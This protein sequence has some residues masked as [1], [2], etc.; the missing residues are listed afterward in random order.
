MY[1][2]PNKNPAKM[3]G[4]LYGHNQAE[5]LEYGLDD[6]LEGILV[7]VLVYVK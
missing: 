4:L 1:P 7:A 3:T 2:E 6:A 5:G